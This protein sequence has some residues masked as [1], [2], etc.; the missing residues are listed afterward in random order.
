MTP[1]RTSFQVLREHFQRFPL[2]VIDGPSGSADLITKKEFLRRVEEEH[3]ARVVRSIVVVTIMDGLTDFAR[4]FGEDERTFTVGQLAQIAA[5]PYTVADSWITAKVL[6][7]DG[8][9]STKKE[10]TAS[11]RTA[12]IAALAGGLR[13][14]QTVPIPLKA[15][16]NVGDVVRAIGKVRPKV[17][18]VA[19]T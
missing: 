13:R 14:R 16:R 2:L 18:E 12:L 15:L 11:Y 17:S 6:T 9:D 10:R 19:A 7:I 8:S 4:F 5:V 1:K 3:K